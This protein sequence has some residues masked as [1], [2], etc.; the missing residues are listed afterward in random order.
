ML[1][2]QETALLT[3][4]GFLTKL[5]DDWLDEKIYNDA[6]GRSCGTLLLLIVLACFKS[7]VATLTLLAMTLI[8][9][10]NQ[11]LDNMVW[12]GFA[13][14]SSAGWLFYC[15]Q[16]AGYAN[17]SFAFLL[18]MLP[19]GIVV[20]KIDEV[21]ETVS[22]PARRRLNKATALLTVGVLSAVV[23]L[24]L[25]GTIQSVLGQLPYDAASGVGLWGLGYM[26]ARFLHPTGPPARKPS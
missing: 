26:L 11:Q 16:I 15:V 3:A 17:G 19:S 10:C 25:P 22:C 2:W 9:L 14:L 21:V 24:G 6:T 13:L 4:V 7:S 18:A 5:V 8:S 1:S 20:N 12:M 23:H